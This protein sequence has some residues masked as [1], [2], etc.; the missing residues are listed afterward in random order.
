MIVFLL[1]FTLSE[2]SGEA[3]SEEVVN[4]DAANKFSKLGSLS[5]LGALPD[6]EMEGE[7]EEK[8]R[9]LASGANPQVSARKNK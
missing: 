7:E 8:H 6:E 3:Q 1:P 2:G 9:F 5:Q 4:A